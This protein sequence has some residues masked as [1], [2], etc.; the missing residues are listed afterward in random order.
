[1]SEGILF[2]TT[3][4]KVMVHSAV[5]PAILTTSSVNELVISAD[6]NEVS[7]DF[8]FN[9]IDKI[10]IEDSSNPLI[11]LPIKSETSA[12][13]LGRNVS[14]CTFRGMNSL[15]NITISE[16]LTSIDQSLFEEC[17][18][19]TSVVIPN[20]VTTIGQSAFAGC[21]GLTAAAIPNSVIDLG[22]SVFSGC[23]GLTS[24]GISNSVSTIGDS[25]F[26][27]CS[28][29]TSVV[30][31]NS[32]ITIGRSAFEGCSGLTSVVIP[33][34]VTTIGRS[35]FALCSG[36]TSLTI[37]NSATTIDEDAFLYCRG[38]TSVVIPNSV[39]TIGRSAFEGCSGLTSL[40][41][42]NALPSISESTFANC[43][44]LTAVVIPESITNIGD[45]AFLNCGFTSLSIPKSITTIGN[46][47]FLGC[48][49][50]AKLKFEDGNEFIA[51]GENVFSSIL[52]TEAYLG[53][54]MDFTK[55]SYAKMESLTFGTQVSFISTNAFVDGNAVRTV[56]SY[57]PVPPSTENI[58]IFSS[59]T[60]LDGTLYVPESSIEAYKTANSWKNFW[61]IK[62]I[63]GYSGVNEIISDIDTS[64]IS[65]E[66]GSIYVN[67]A[68]LV[69]IVTMKGANVYKGRGNC[70]VNVEPGIYIIII[71]NT[72][73]KVLVK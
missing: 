30:I 25:V 57:N 72:N 50:I 73:Y 43:R 62:P 65:I 2:N 59:K 5:L 16:K 21:K 64:T 71:G 68:S 69:N 24:L 19:L 52:P 58:D 33:N 61:E 55:I 14:S 34:S 17:C 10:T 27:E 12:L 8:Q 1:M 13:Y 18:G 56:I 66:N 54:Q 28:G 4:E 42:S 48:D 63:P 67:S 31:P 41:I 29:L 36:L 39:T 51:I 53:R 3:L 70:K 60:Y 15:E 37:S 22:N 49:S 6:V 40:T 26:F 7:A 47:A 20:S 11:T 46:A 35:A 23:S 38:L 45:L 32:V 44:G 9:T